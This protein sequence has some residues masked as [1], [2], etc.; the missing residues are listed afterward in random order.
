MELQ[1]RRF[2]EILHNAVSKNDSCNIALSGGL[3]S[4]AIAYCA[5]GKKPKAHVVIAEDF[6][7]NDLTYSQMIASKLNLPLE[8]IKV[9]TKDMISG[10]DKTI[11]ILKNF[12][13][14]EIRNS[15]VMYITL[16]SMKKRGEK[17]IITGD[18][19]DEL[20]AGYNFLLKKTDED[21]QKE[22]H[23]I[24]EIMHFPSKKIGIALGINVETPF[25]DKAMREF[26]Q[27]LPLNQKI[28]M[29]KG[30]KFGKWIIRKSF[31]SKI[32]DSIVW[33]QKTPMQDGAGTAGLTGLF[34][35]VI[36]DDV[37]SE[38]KEKI[39]KDDGIIIRT[40]ESLHYYQMYKKHFGAPSSGKTENI[41][42]D[43]KCQTLEDSKFC[44][45]CGRFE[46]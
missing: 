29:Y 4:S 1:S 43:C 39:N 3:D 7:A 19:A 10:I 37:F 25:L 32:P 2:L 34:D 33:R 22:L 46:G 13:D 44:R 42:P 28:R 11:K 18:G 20:F 17:S 23:R 5:R 30:K 38:Q 31:E 12:N 27:K 14:I 36:P 40:K 6:L 24:T 15:L 8:I 26:A 41:C 9:T 21:L 35:A 45:M 16:E